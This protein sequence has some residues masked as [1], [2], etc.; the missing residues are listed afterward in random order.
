MNIRTYMFTWNG[1]RKFIDAS[2]YSEARR[3][4]MERFGFF[5]DPKTVTIELLPE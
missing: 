4:F 3:K 1:R 5:P 2:T